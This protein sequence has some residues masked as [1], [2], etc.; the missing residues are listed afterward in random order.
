MVAVLSLRVRILHKSSTEFKLH[1]KFTQ[2]KC[3]KPVIFHQKEEPKAY[4]EPCQASIIELSRSR[5]YRKLKIN[6]SMFNAENC[7][8]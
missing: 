6:P 2:V 3:V 4:S 5:W 8:T 7:Q 1:V